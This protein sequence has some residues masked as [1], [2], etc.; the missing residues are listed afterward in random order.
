[1]ARAYRRMYRMTQDDRWLTR[2]ESTAREAIALDS[3]RADAHETLALALWDSGRPDDAVSQMRR[4]V[5]L[6]PTDEDAVIALGRFHGRRG[7]V[8]EEEA[9]YRE[10]ADGRPHAWKPHYWLAT[11]V[12]YEH[13]RFDEAREAFAEMIRRAPEHHIG[14]ESLGGL[15]VLDGEYDEAAK[16][17]QAAIALHPSAE[18]LTNLGAAYFNQRNFDRAVDTFNEVFRH[19]FADYLVWINLADAYYFAPGRRGLADEAYRQGIRLGRAVIEDRPYDAA[20]LAHLARAFA[21]VGEAD[22]ARAYLD[23]ALETDEDNPMVHYCAA[24]THWQ[25]GERDRALDWLESAI[26]GGHPVQW[27]E[28]SPTFDEWRDVERFRSLVSRSPEAPGNES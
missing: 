26:E 16:N 20:A 23:R 25:L 8:E 17:L 19:D 27:L 15:Q 1:M 3:T 21:T 10:A 4:A 22:S 11:K 6:D 24:L 2:A 14:Y 7:L 18:A 9:I 13:G 28:D 12:F 5:E